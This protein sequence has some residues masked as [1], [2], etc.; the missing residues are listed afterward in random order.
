MTKRLVKPGDLVGGRF[1]ISGA[2]LGEGSF[3]E[4]CGSRL[5]RN[6]LSERGANATLTPPASS[7][8]QVYPATDNQTKVEVRA[9]AHACLRHSLA[10][11]P[12]AVNW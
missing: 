10:T 1:R 8:A 11:A 12:V 7:H 5:R 2:L 9:R 4:V 3:S 6:A